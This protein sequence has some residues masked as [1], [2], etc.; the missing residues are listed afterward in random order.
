MGERLGAIRVV[1]DGQVALEAAL[2]DGSGGVMIVGTGS[3]VL[4]RTKEGRVLSVGGWGYLLGDEGS[5]H[6]IGLAGLKLVVAAF[7]GR[8]TG[9]VPDLVRRQFS[10]QSRADLIHRV[11]RAQWALQEVAPLVIA[12]A[13][14]GD[15]HALEIL[16]AEAEGLIGQVAWMV[17]QAGTD[18]EPRLAMLGGL[19]RETFYRRMLERVLEARCPGWR[20]VPPV[21][22]KP[23]AGAV[24]LARKAAH[25]IVDG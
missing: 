16:E 8:P 15:A 21:H 2:G 25:A 22:P 23:V 1:E 20:V 5:G 12:A 24:R 7:E 18:I 13:A 11:Y 6:A 14:S 10:I 4:G 17:E 3:V 19:S 9:A